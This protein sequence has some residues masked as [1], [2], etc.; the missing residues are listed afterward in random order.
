MQESDSVLHLPNGG[1]AVNPKDETRE[2]GSSTERKRAYL[3]EFVRS[4]CEGGV[5]PAEL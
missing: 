5:G 1:F 3:N 4:R 2:T